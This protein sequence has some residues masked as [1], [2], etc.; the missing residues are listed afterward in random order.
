METK[1]RSLLRVISWRITATVTTMVISWGIT[2]NIDFALKIGMI[3]VVAKIALQYL[4]ER[5]WMRI[6]LGLNH[7]RDYQI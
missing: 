3:E 2:G 4:H 6:K 7:V 5:I 1:R